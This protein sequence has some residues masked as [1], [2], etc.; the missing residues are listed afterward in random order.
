MFPAPDLNCALLKNT[1]IRII[2]LTLLDHCVNVFNLLKKSCYAE[3]CLS[4]R[5]ECFEDF[6]EGGVFWNVTLCS[7]FNPEFQ[8]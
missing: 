6:E 4:S 3:K 1:I 2:F 8:F 5:D 7:K